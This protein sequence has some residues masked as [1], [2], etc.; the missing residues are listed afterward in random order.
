MRYWT[1]FVMWWAGR[2]FFFLVVIWFAATLVK[3]KSESN[4]MT[5]KKLSWNGAA[6][7]TPTSA[8]ESAVNIPEVQRQGKRTVWIATMTLIVGLG[9]GYAS[10]DLQ[11]RMRTNTLYN[12][13]VL[14][15]PAEKEFYLRTPK[16]DLHTVFCEPVPFK[17]GDHIKKLKYEN[18]TYCWSVEDQKLGY[19][20]AKGDENNGWNTNADPYTYALTF[21]NP[22]TAR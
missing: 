7:L 13:T 6:E 11:M 16:E 2:S 9:L 19:Q 4:V 15:Q 5:T 17:T 18:R 12:V 1:L 8:A 3:K 14:S 22:Y 21:T 20:Y 10:R